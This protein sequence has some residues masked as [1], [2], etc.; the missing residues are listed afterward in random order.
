MYNFLKIS[1][2]CEGD[3]S[4]E[5]AKEERGLDHGGGRVRGKRGV[6]VNEGREAGQH[7]G[8]AHLN[9]AKYFC[10]G[11]VVVNEGGEAGQHC[12]PP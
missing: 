8:H 7:C 1:I 2:T 11:G 6:V 12:R 9:T 5:S 4:D 3:A 10:K